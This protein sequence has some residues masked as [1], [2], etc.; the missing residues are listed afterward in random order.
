VIIAF[1]KGPKE[2]RLILA[3]SEHSESMSME[4]FERGISTCQL[5]EVFVNPKEVSAD[6]R[7]VEENDSTIRELR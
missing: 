7:V 5:G 3:H 1:V 6:V 2:F 4:E